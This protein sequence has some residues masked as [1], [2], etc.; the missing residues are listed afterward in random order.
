MAET[1][2]EDSIG[3]CS[4]K[5]SAKLQVLWI[6]GGQAVGKPPAGALQHLATRLEGR[7]YLLSFQLFE[8]S[9]ESGALGGVHRFY[10]CPVLKITK[11]NFMGLVD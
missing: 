5:Q 10:Q 11:L 6:P 1:I 9:Q 2:R 3:N 7:L 8:E 4:L